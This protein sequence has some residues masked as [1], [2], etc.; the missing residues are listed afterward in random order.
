[1]K[2][3]SDKLTCVVWC[4]FSRWGDSGERCPVEGR[5]VLHSELLGKRCLLRHKSLLMRDERNMATAWRW[6]YFS[7]FTSSY[8]YIV[9]KSRCTL[10]SVSPS[11]QQGLSEL[12]KK[13]LQ[14]IVFSSFLKCLMV[15]DV[16]RVVWIRVNSSHENAQECCMAWSCDW[17]LVHSLLGIQHRW[18]AARVHLFILKSNP[19]LC[20]KDIKKTQA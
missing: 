12:H 16:L 19:I 14:L 8:I 3:N 20:L 13:Q 2:D 11:L 1:M 15:R 7:P 5:E 18:K 4:C 6:R 17:D 9:L 10:R